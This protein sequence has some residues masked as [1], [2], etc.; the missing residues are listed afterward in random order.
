MFIAYKL[1]LIDMPSTVNL[2]FDNEDRNYNYT[3]CNYSA[4]HVYNMLGV[5]LMKKID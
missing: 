2:E 1:D 5:T 3:M 4:S